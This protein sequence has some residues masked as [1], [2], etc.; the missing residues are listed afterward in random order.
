MHNSDQVKKGMVIVIILSIFLLAFLVLKPIII[1][2]IFGL[3]F[4]YIFGP[5]YK[6]LHSIIKR[7]SLSA[8]LIVI[9]FII[10]VGVPIVYIVPNL[11]NQ[12][13]ETYMKFQNL[14]VAEILGNLMESGITSSLAKN[15]DNIVGQI[16]SSFLNQFTDILVNLPS[17]MLH[18]AVFLFTF[19]F[20][21]RDGEKLREN[22]SSLSPFSKHMEIKI[23]NEFRGITNAIVFGQMLI[24]VIQGLALGAGLFFLGVPNILTLTFIACIVSIIPLVGSWTVWLPVGV[25]MLIEGQ[26]W[27]G[28][29]LLLY[30]ALF[31][32]TIDNFLRPYILSKQSRLPVAL[33]II[34]TVGGLYLFGI[35]GILL[36]PL[37]LAY[38]LIIIEFYQEGKLRELFEK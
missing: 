21:V 6:K 35:A 10:L 13:F 38:V 31:V 24:G 11:V 18:F 36:G 14:N 5:V 8:F 27:Q 3:L 28:A 33:S 29:F 7:K 25:F 2:I 1:P 34:G 30:G 9:G 26:I 23:M 32:S 19:F 22:V 15:I 37:I 16:F 20:A 12:T 4:A 17:L